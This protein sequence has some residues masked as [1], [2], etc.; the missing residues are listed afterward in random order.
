MPGFIPSFIP[1]F[2]PGFST[3]AF[4]TKLGFIPVSCQFHALFHT[5]T[6]KLAL[7]LETGHETSMKPNA[8][9]NPLRIQHA[10]FMTRFTPYPQISP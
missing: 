9:Q 7:I 4:T 1:G 6:P 8:I 2:M 10:G 5:L 3:S